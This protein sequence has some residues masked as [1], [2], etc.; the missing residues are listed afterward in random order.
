GVAAMPTNRV[1]ARLTANRVRLPFLAARFL[2]PAQ[3]R[4]ASGAADL[5][6]NALYTPEGDSPFRPF[7]FQALDTHGSVQIADLAA[8]LPQVGVPLER[9]NGTA[10]F[11]TD[12]LLT[13]LSGQVA[14]TGVAVKGSLF[15]LPQLL[16]RALKN[17]QIARLPG[18]AAPTVAL[19]GSL[20][21]LDLARLSADPRL[22]QS[23][24]MQI[25]RLRRQAGPLSGQAN[26]DFQIAGAVENPTATLAARFEG[27]RSPNVQIGNVEVRALLANRTL[28]ADARAHYARGDLSVRGQIAL[29]KTGAYRVEAHGR[30]AQ[31]DALGLAL[32]QTLHGHG[33]LD[34]IAQGRRGEL[35]H[36]TGQAQVHD[37]K[38]DNQTLNTL[39]AK[40][41][42]TG[43]RLNVRT[44]R[45][46]D[47]KGFV[48][49]RGTVDLDKRRLNLMLEGDELDFGELSNTLPQPLRES[50]PPTPNSSPQEQGEGSVSI[51]GIGYVRGRV[52]GTLRS[53][54]FRGRLS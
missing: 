25:A 53:P 11:T 2:P 26:A 21:H 18:Q 39:Y 34:L 4:V 50:R 8:S 13:D 9:V 20:S 43:N 22:P 27:L 10:T 44:L 47:P 28:Y 29:D 7:Q 37:I 31:L 19:Q 35:P 15:G 40:V 12:S 14:G 48:L 46:E 17:P 33:D 54:L 36:V 30:N 3:G 23:L 45:L 42:T 24:K 5:I 52:T 32:K 49:A 1:Q 51:A 16:S 6:L 38:L 41:D